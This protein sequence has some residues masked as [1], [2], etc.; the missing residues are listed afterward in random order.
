MHLYYKYHSQ[1]STVQLST[2]KL[3]LADDEW[4]FPDVGTWPFL[5]MYKRPY[6]SY[7]EM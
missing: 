6:V 4:L 1:S 7:I 2:C 5:K 3:S